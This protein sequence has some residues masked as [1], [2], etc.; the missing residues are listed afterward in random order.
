MCKLDDP[1]MPTVTGMRRRGYTPEAIEILRPNWVWPKTDN[2]IDVDLLEH[3][4]REDLNEPRPE[5]CAS[6]GHCA[7]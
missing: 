7:L 3:C 4:V 2:L 6:C 5:Q 1:R